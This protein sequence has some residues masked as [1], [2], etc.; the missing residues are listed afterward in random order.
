MSRMKKVTLVLP[1]DL[2]EKARKA[3]RQNFTATVR[4]ALEIVAATEIYKKLL[5]LEGKVKL[6]INLNEIRKDREE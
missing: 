4:Q 5:G 6:K 3:T 2:I 1:A